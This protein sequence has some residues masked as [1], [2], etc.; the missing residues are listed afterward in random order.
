MKHACSPFN[1][2]LLFSSREL[3][4]TISISRRNPSRKVI[5]SFSMIPY[6]NIFLENCRQ[7]GWDHMKSMKFIIMALSL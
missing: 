3:Y 1:E 7:G 4:G 6:F 2:Q 5:G